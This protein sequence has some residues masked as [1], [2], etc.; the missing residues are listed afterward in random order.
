MR[1]P[2]IIHQ[3]WLGD[4]PRP[5]VMVDWFAR[6]CELHPSWAIWEWR[7]LPAGHLQQCTDIHGQ[8]N[9]QAIIRPSAQERSLLGRACHLSQRSNIWR[10]LVLQQFGGLYVDTDVEPIRPI[11]FLIEELDVFAAQ[12]RNAGRLIVE[13]A[14]MGAV[15]GHPWIRDAIASLRTRDPTATLSMGTA[16][17]T[18]VTA[19]HPEVVL[20]P[21]DAVVFEQPPDWE[22]AKRLAVV[23]ARDAGAKAFPNAHAVHHWGSLWHKLGFVPLKIPATRNV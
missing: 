11:D 10:Y 18:A 22:E 14:F 1:I 19:R 8:R 12:R 7:E 21:K 9:G 23:P 3:I 6:W 17:L 4:L 16:Y 5:Q 13:T 15:P 2:R 20:L